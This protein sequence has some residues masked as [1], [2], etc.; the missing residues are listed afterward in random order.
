[1]ESNLTS[2]YISKALTE[3]STHFASGD[4]LPA[5]ETESGALLLTD[6]SGCTRLTAALIRRYDAGIE[7][8]SHLLNDFFSELIDLVESRGGT[9]FSFS[10][11]AVL[12]GWQAHSSGPGLEEAAWRCCAC[13]REINEHFG[14]RRVN[15]EELKLRIS[16]GAGEVSLIHL[17]TGVHRSFLLTDGAAVDQVS[18]CGT[19]ADKDEILV[20][21]EAWTLVA[22]HCDGDIKHSSVVRLRNVSQPDPPTCFQGNHSTPVH[23]RDLQAYFSK[24][25]LK[26]FRS[27]FPDWLEELRAVTVCFLQLFDKSG[28][29]GVSQFDVAILHIL[30][31]VERLGGDLLEAESKEQGFNTLIVFGLPGESHED[32]PRRALMAAL[33]LQASPVLK[34]WGVSCGIA[35][36]QVLCG[37]VGGN[38]YAE[39]TV[40][41]DAVNLAARFV[42]VAAGRILTDEETATAASSAILFEGPWPIQIPGIRKPLKAFIPVSRKA[43][44]HISEAAHPVGRKR[45]LQYLVSQLNGIGTFRQA[46]VSVSGEAG[47]GKSALVGALARESRALGI[48]VIEGHADDLEQSTAYFIWL[49]IIRSALGI[50]SLQGGQ[51][52][53]ETV[54]AQV[55]NNQDLSRFT[56]LLNDVLNLKIADNTLT[57]KMSSEVRARNL[58][59]LLAWIVGRKLEEGPAVL[60]LEDVHWIDSASLNLFNAVMISGA[61]VLA[62]LTSRPPDTLS[63]FTE[64]LPDSLLKNHSRLLLDG[65]GHTDSLDLAHQYLEAGTMPEWFRKFVIDSSGGNPL[66]IG[67]L[68]RVFKQSDVGELSRSVGT[69]AGSRSWPHPKSVGSLVLSRIDGL[70]VES[71]KLIKIVS[72]AGSHFSVEELQLLRP[73][74]M[75]GIN[76]PGAV[77]Q[78]VEKQLLQEL[79]DQPGRYQFRHSIIRDVVYESMLTTQ[80]QEAHSAVAAALE[81][82]YGSDPQTMPLVLHHWRCA[83]EKL[84]IMEY[85][86]RVAGLKLKQFDTGSA[87]QLIQELFALAGKDSLPVS[88]LDGAS[89]EFIRAEAALGEGKMELARSSYEKGLALLGTPVPVGSANLLL[90]LVRETV[91]QIWSRI[92]RRKLATNSTPVNSL[93]NPGRE[94]FL[95][96]A[97]AHDALTKIYYFTGEKVRLLHATLRATNLAE[98]YGKIHPAVAINYASLGAICGVI[99]LRSQAR[100]YATRADLIVHQFDDPP[101]SIHVHLLAGLYKTAVGDWESAEHEFRAGLE[102][103]HALGDMRRWSE[104]AVGLETIAGPWLLTPCYPGADAWKSL[105]DQVCKIGRER[106]DLQV[107]ACGLLGRLRGDPVLY[108]HNEEME[109]QLAELKRLVDSHSARLELIHCVEAAGHLASAAL[110]RGEPETWLAWLNRGKK[111]LHQVNPGMK[112]RTLPALAA[113][114]GACIDYDTAKVKFAPESAQCI[115]TAM[116]ISGKLRHFSRIYPIGQPAALRCQGDLSVVRGHR[117][118]GT[119]LWHQSLRK[120]LELKM[121]RD[122]I[123]AYSRL[124]EE[125]QLRAGLHTSLKTLLNEH[126][127]K[128]REAYQAGL[129]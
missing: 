46:I 102:T 91:A 1:M 12:A 16:V 30:E 45:E 110:R 48:P 63:R 124:S 24:A 123:A 49:D 32:D 107:L 97:R 5:I 96:A 6:I 36:G 4:D 37:V 103:A 69:D 87:I 84:K 44:A 125:E 61:K 38:H 85:L 81:H 59:S 53:E 101:A 121:P 94:S 21:R 129:D 118:R 106:A 76:V 74:A 2:R 90:F 67:E 39:Y 15:S 55:N 43:I 111:F 93:P 40:L 19:L 54:V 52:A 17:G 79:N 98:R 7:H 114:F 75:A 41:G 122:A 108:P 78:L 119:R 20:S 100:Y 25:L 112:S 31:V 26:R 120:A 47:I 89:Y 70:P 42:S 22:Q 80:R 35:T 72:V 65:L 50:D 68:C 18:F 117:R 86:G 51:S 8:V 109:E 9:I 73:V 62:V 88:P 13:A 11:D 104:L 113:M 82:K 3:W 116:T 23:S 14:G 126:A 56:P 27:P 60:I 66:F 127:D 33:E 95:I 105:A 92:T 83:G 115:S 29:A 57:A 71:R 77:A 28:T 99:P 58:L 10:G 64:H 34:H 128:W